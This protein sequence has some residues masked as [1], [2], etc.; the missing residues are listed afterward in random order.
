ALRGRV[1]WS[2]AGLAVL[3]RG[4]RTPAAVVDAHRT[5]EPPYAAGPQAARAGASAMIDV[6]D[7]LLADL[8]HVAEASGVVVDV[9]RDALVVPERLR[10][11]G[12]AVGV[13]PRHWMLTGGEDHA[14]AATFPGEPPAGW[15]GIGTVHEGEAAVLVDGKPYEGPAGWDHF[16][17]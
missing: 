2:A 3:L 16:R 7:G 8:G 13:D 11:A 14:L 10:D 12:A 5:P 4:L 6:S 17:S 1:G 9:R 15:T